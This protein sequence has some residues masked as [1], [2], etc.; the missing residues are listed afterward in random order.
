[1]RAIRRL[2]AGQRGLRRIDLALG[3][4]AHLRA[5]LLGQGSSGRPQLAHKGSASSGDDLGHLDGRRLGL[6]SLPRRVAT[7]QCA[8]A[9]SGE[10]PLGQGDAAHL[11]RP[12]ADGLTAP[13]R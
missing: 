4:L 2:G 12:Q 3:L 6:L 10:L 11:R 7:D 13:A 1:M 8:G 5:A 9:H